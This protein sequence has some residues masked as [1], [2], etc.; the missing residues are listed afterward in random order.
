[1]GPGIPGPRLFSRRTTVMFGISFR[2]W[3]SPK[4]KTA[5]LRLLFLLLLLP[6]ALHGQVKFL[7]GDAND[8]GRVSISDAHY[9]S[10][11][12]YG[13]G[14]P[15]PCIK[16]ADANDDGKVSLGGLEGDLKNDVSIIVS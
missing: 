10:L 9:I 5:A 2:P 12:L 13:G 1:M 16:A 15:P 3:K 11:W 4:I 14:P 8:D 6:P 7:R